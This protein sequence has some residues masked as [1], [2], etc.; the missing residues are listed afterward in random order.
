[1]RV[2]FHDKKDI[3]IR[4]WDKYKSLSTIDPKTFESSIS[5]NGSIIYISSESPAFNF[6]SCQHSSLE[7]LIPNSYPQLITLTGIVKAGYVS[8]D[9]QNGKSL[10]SIDLI[11]EVGYIEVEQALTNYLSLS[12][13]LGVIEVSDTI[14]PFDTKIQTL[15]G[16]LRTFDLITKN[17]HAL[18]QYGCSMHKN[19]IA[20]TIKVDTK[21]GFSTILKS[22]SLEQAQDIDISTEYGGSTL[23]IDN[24]NVNFILGSKK[25]Q[26][27]VEFED[28]EWKC[29]VDTFS[30][31]TMNGKC[32]LKVIQKIQEKVNVKLSMN[33]KYGSS[34]LFIDHFESE[35]M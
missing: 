32:S 24:P 14:V 31:K 9:G 34:D 17:F 13:E 10:K 25:G 26:M 21:F 33:T 4:L 1:V 7:I 3:Q 12:T 6:H 18:T 22:S 29:K 23:A 19:L 8:I 16:S 5:Q 11:V 30:N 15:F 35:D 2:S 27:F 20:D 28:E